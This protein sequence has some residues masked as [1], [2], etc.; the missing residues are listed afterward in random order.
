MAILKTVRRCK[1]VLIL[2]GSVAMSVLRTLQTGIPAGLTHDSNT[3]RGLQSSDG[4]NVAAV[5]V[6]SVERQYKE[7]FKKEN[8]QDGP[9]ICGAKKCMIP[10]KQDA[11][12]GYLVVNARQPGNFPLRMA[13][14][15]NFS[16]SVIEEQ[17]NMSH[18][19]LDEPYETR[20]D[21]D[22]V[23]WMRKDQIAGYYG[24]KRVASF[25]KHG[26]WLIQP[27]SVVPQDSSILFGCESKRIKDAIYNLH[28][29]GEQYFKNQS[30]WI[31][32]QSL[33]ERVS[34]EFDKLFDLLHEHPC[35][36]DDFQ[37]FLDVSSGN[38]IHIDVDRCFPLKD[39]ESKYRDVET[40]C[41][42][43]MKDFKGYIISKL[44]EFQQLYSSKSESQWGVQRLIRKFKS[45]Q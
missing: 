27:I 20:V 17:Y 30:E 22:F 23:Q 9:H 13:Q 2:G 40:S 10:L 14:A 31:D 37:M 34:M 12:V 29:M 25:S 19:Y 35:L 44:S 24:Q 1:V 3:Q 4:N 39:D 16:K 6:V 28:Q 32:Y 42:P 45:G 7:D 36:Y 41:L 33:K 21:D 8:L 5:P 18:V 15:Y 43:L 38:V 26:Q 11:S